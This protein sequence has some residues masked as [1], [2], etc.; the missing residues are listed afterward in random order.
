MSH[1]NTL[2]KKHALSKYSLQPSI[3]ASKKKQEGAVLAIG[4]LMLLII[5]FVAVSGM[6]TSIMSERMAANAQSVNRVFQA[7]EVSVAIA[8]GT[9]NWVDDALAL[10]GIAEEDLP[11]GWPTENINMNENNALATVE[12]SCG[13]KPV[14]GNSLNGSIVTYQ[15][16][17]NGAATLTDSNAEKILVAGFIQTGAS[18]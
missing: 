3:S 14:T 4:L 17:I 5:T 11:D 13:Y 1:S 2:L 15:L 10:C 12:L 6:E 9:D 8:V 18:K 7:A 16:A